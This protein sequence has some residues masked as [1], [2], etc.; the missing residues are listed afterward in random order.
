[1]EEKMKKKEEKTITLSN[2]VAFMRSNMYSYIMFALALL[3]C[4]YTLYNVEDYQQKVNNKW[5]EF[6][7]ESCSCSNYYKPNVTFKLAT[8]RDMI[9]NYKRSNYNESVYFVGG[10]SANEQEYLYDIKELN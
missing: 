1:M 9:D 8:P 10:V 2:I 3:A 4:L 6:I 7:S 5:M